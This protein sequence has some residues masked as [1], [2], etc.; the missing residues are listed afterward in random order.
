MR[1][2]LDPVHFFDE[3]GH[4]TLSFD[5]L[6]EKLQ[7]A[8]AEIERLTRLTRMLRAVRRRDAALKE[9]IPDIIQ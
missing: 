1:Q 3:R 4:S 7:V 2:K 6:C 5:H 8:E 9:E